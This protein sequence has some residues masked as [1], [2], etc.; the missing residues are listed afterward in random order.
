[1]TDPLTK[2]SKNVMPEEFSSTMNLMA[3]PLAGMAATGAIGLGLASQAFGMWMGAV[4]GMGEASH[5]MWAGLAEPSPK[6]QT[7]TKLRLVA[8]QATPPRSQSV[9]KV[10]KA[11][12]VAAAHPA[13]FDNLKAISGI[14]PKLEKLLNDKGIWTYGQIAALEEAQIVSLDKELGFSGRISRDD[15]IGQATALLAGK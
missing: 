14:G 2:A 7:A 9:A 15:W 3:H 13:K 5:K 12:P 1:M 10:T 4:A 6:P 11:K 8:S